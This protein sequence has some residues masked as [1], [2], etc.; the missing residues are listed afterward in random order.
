MFGRL[1]WLHLCYGRAVR[2]IFGCAGTLAGTPTC[3]VRPPCN[4]SSHPLKNTAPSELYDAAQTRQSALV[5]LLRLLAGEPDLGARSEDVLDGT[6][7]AL[8]YLAADAE[9]LYAAAEKGGRA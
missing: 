3:T 7:S 9:R 4:P 5:N 8:E 2:G 6:F 1:A